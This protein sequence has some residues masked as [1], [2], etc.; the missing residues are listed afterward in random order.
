MTMSAEK[1]VPLA[2]TV[3][4]A[5]WAC[6]DGA[7]DPADDPSGDAG[8]G[9]DVPSLDGG[10]DGSTDPP[11]DGPT[12]VAADADAGAA[13][14][15][16]DLGADAAG[17]A[18]G[19]VGPC[20]LAPLP[21]P[22]PIDIDQTRFA[23]ALFHFNIEYV[24][25]GLEYEDEDGDMVQFLGWPQMEGWDNEAVEDYIVRETLH[26]ILEMYARH[27]E[28]RVTL[29]MQAYM[30]DVMAERHP[31]TLVLLREL[32]Q[33]GQ[34]ELVSF[35]Y[36]AQLFLAYPRE[37]LERSQARVRETFET[38]CL[39]LS[40]V[41]FN[42]EGQAGEGRQRLLVEQGWEI[43]VF[44]K[45]L[46]RYVR[47][48]DP[49]WPYY[50]SE[51]G[52]L[53]VGPGGVNPASGIEVTWPFFDDGELRAVDN[54]MNP[55]FAPMG[56]H[57]P[58]RVAEYEAQLQALAD[59]GW[60]L[61][62]ITDYVRQLEGMGV[63]RP[64]A[65]PLLDGTWQPPS[66]DSIHRWLGGRSQANAADEEDNRVRSGNAV[67]RMHVAATQRLVDHA[68][69]EG[70]DTASWD[71]AMRDAWEKLWHA[72]VSDAS[73]V[74]PWRAEV[75]WCLRLNDELL[76]DAEALRA[77]ILP[78]LEMSNVAIDLEDG[79]VE[80]IGGVPIPEAPDPTEAPFELEL[81]GDGREIAVSWFR[82]GGPDRKVVFVSFGPV[83]VDESC[84]ECDYRRLAVGFPHT[85]DD[86]AYSPGLI[87]DE[88]RSYPL[89]AFTFLED[90]AYLPLPNGLIGLGDDR[91]VIKHVRET[92]IAARI[93]PSDDHVRFIDAAL[94]EGDTP[95]W[96]FEYFEGTA[97][98][99]L[100]IANRINVHPLVF[101]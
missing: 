76:A 89:D 61:T 97:E 51:G 83:A 91:W 30:V 95:T 101:Y 88:V 73:G 7:A 2:L 28:W 21:D 33:R 56:P 74:N 57:S 14:T 17:G 48:D 45:N 37:D 69:A 3:C 86:L 66:T 70:L 20:T 87:E 29:E 62:S 8:V 98:E 59:E 71:A 40:G 68:R 99:A 47:G 52:T 42:Q 65:P 78:A 92:H 4:L 15:V 36:A 13:D 50:E 16:E 26:P 49:W 55:Y 58:E 77:E 18:D 96:A 53:I 39:P 60:K 80:G 54:L 9:R 94:R 63:A 11:V 90:E 46:W 81:V 35:H 31:E 100:A 32:A 64:A 41:V 23:L 27:P 43:G 79:S 85:G 10:S 6:N 12:D 82:S 72:E 24:I 67:A 38:H 34:A 1:L 22:D 84:P 44:P 75:L 5:T 25:G 93:S 19:S